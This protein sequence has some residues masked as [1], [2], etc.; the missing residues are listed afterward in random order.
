MTVE[1][2]FLIKLDIGCGVVGSGDVNCDLY[3]NDAGHRMTGNAINTRRVKNFV[4]CDAQHLPFKDEAFDWV[5]SSHVIEH[6]D[7]PFAM[8]REMVRVA[9]IRVTVRCPHR[10]GERFFLKQSPYHVNFFGAAWF[11]KAF[12]KLNCI[13]IVDII[14]Y[15]S[16]PNKFITLLRLP[17]EMQIDALKCNSPEIS[18]IITRVGIERAYEILRG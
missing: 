7:N 15:I 9:R 1:A 10:L 13:S 12:R 17:Y 4:S 2:E 16:F 5:Y 18:E 11:G 3:V 8:L 6:V 14:N